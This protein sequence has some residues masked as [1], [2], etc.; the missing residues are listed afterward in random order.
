MSN[1]LASHSFFLTRNKYLPLLDFRFVILPTH[2][3][4]H[5]TLDLASRN[6]YV[7]RQKNAILP[8]LFILNVKVY[9]SESKVHMIFN[10]LRGLS[11]EKY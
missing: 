9:V 3:N 2:F 5:L 6:K 7:H 8:Q 10:V 11:L 4:L 1:A